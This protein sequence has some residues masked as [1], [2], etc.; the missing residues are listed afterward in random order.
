MRFVLN[1]NRY[2]Q[3]EKV[4]LILWTIYVVGYTMLVSTMFRDMFDLSMA[5]KFL[6]IFIELTGIVIYCLDFFINRIISMKTFLGDMLM[7]G[8]TM[9]LELSNFKNNFLICII[10]MLLARGID[11]SRF[12]KYDIKLKIFLFF[13]VLLLC[14]AGVL[15]NYMIE[16][17]GSYKQSLGFY[18]PNMMMVFL[19]SAVVEFMFVYNKKINAVGYVAVALTVYFFS[20]F[21]TSRTP[22]Y[23]FI[24]VFIFFLLLRKYRKVFELKIVRIIATLL[25]PALALLSFLVTFLYIAGNNFA[26]QLNYFLS[27]RIK[28]QAYFLTTY[29]LSIFGTQFKTV[30]TKEAYETGAE[31]AILD[32]AYVRC[33]LDFGIIIFIAMCIMYSVILYRLFLE[34]NYEFAL[35]C[36]FFVVLGLGEAY[37]LNVLYNVS[38]VYFLSLKDKMDDFKKEK[39][40]KEGWFKKQKKKFRFVWGDRKF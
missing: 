35:L 20:L 25:T 27:N 39:H 9:G 14:Y 5:T 19:L 1:K 2:K 3:K 28:F 4:F 13:S 38:L 36:I 30:S 21:S 15:E 24:I 8:L 40:R 34:K 10:F 7:L 22:L 6:Y 33:A 16:V 17:S 12:I 18:H 11:F 23:T 32:N 37:S 29:R 26:I 31:R